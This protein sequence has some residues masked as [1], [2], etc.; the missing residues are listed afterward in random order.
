MSAKKRH[1]GLRVKESLCHALSFRRPRTMN[2][3]IHPSTSE[4]R[5]PSSLNK[6]VVFTPYSTATKNAFAK[7]Y[8]RRY[9]KEGCS[10]SGEGTA[11]QSASVC[12]W[13]NVR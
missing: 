11:I 9:P 13:K 6:A 7:M 3:H 10:K 2:N 12:K 5:E 1:I 4:F 8:P